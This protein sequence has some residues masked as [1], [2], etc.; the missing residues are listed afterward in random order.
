M[1]LLELERADQLAVQDPPAFGNFHQSSVIEPKCL[2]VGA[3]PEL[4]ERIVC[5]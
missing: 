5:V 1:F 4:W 3:D 2:S